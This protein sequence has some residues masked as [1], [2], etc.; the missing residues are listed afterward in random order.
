[1]SYSPSQH[2]YFICSEQNQKHVQYIIQCP[3]GYQGINDLQ[4]P[5]TKPNNDKPCGLRDCKIRACCVPWPGVLK[6]VPN[7][8]VDC[9]VS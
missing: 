9:S 6:G 2:H 3:T 7:R 1:M 4:V 8:G 5:E